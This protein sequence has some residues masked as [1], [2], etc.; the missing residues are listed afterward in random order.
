MRGK[1]GK[2]F[3]GLV[4]FVCLLL[5]LLETIFWWKRTTVLEI[6]KMEQTM[7]D[8]FERTEEGFREDFGL[9]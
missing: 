3:L 8:E 1:R 4:L 2:Y 9:K 5:L 6:D 7:R